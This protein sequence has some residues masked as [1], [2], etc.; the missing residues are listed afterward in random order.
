MEV[1][2][3]INLSVVT[4]TASNSEY[5][6]YS[7]S[8]KI[9]SNAIDN[10]CSSSDSENNKENLKLINREDN[11]RVVFT[12]LMNVSNDE[13]CSQIN[14]DNEI[15]DSEIVMMVPDLDSTL[16]FKHDTERFFMTLSIAEAE[17]DLARS[18]LKS[19]D[20]NTEKIRNAH[21]GTNCL[22]EIKTYVE[23]LLETVNEAKDSTFSY[24]NV[25]ADC[26]DILQQNFSSDNIALI[27]TM[28]MSG[29]PNQAHIIN[30]E[31]L[32]MLCEAV[33]E[34]NIY[35]KKE[36][37]LYRS[38][39]E[40]RCEYENDEIYSKDVYK[41]EDSFNWK[42]IF[43][44][45]IFFVFLLTIFNPAGI[46]NDIE[47][48]NNRKFSIEKESNIYKDNMENNQQQILFN[49]QQMAKNMDILNH[50]PNE[51]DNLS[52]CSILSELDIL[53]RCFTRIRLS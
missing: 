31:K 7:N 41:D 1:L 24:Q 18:T 20:V 51:L 33:S 34:E 9:E 25:I 8:N 2:N 27:N 26:C 28:D 47:S 48:K 46:S 32:K 11:N 39:E 42:N 49:F 50:N 13:N 17:L 38:K 10:A 4:T 37:E 35:L 12:N 6:M 53:E 23:E 5:G 19:S 16:K 40:Y 15:A 45:F 43:V 36:I 21:N 30:T 29:V 3:D 52:I 22:K 44:K 14:S